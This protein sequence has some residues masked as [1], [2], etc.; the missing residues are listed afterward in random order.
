MKKPKQLTLLCYF[1]CCRV[2][3]LKTFKVFFSVG[4]PVKRPSTPPV[5]CNGILNLSSPSQNSFFSLAI[6][7]VDADNVKGKGGWVMGL[8]THISHRLL[9]PSTRTNTHT[10]THIKGLK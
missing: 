4:S 6:W 8:Q 3:F 1:K 10:N 9:G 2:W 7:T 5:S